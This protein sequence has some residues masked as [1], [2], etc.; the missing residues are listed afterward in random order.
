MLSITRKRLGLLWHV[1]KYILIITYEVNSLQINWTLFSNYTW[2]RVTQDEVV[3]RRLRSL[4]QG[5][6]NSVHLHPIYYAV[7]RWQ[8]SPFSCVLMNVYLRRKFASLMKG[9]KAIHSKGINFYR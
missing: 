8:A 6:F 2:E 4:L 1:A 7:R 5:L 9:S 3:G